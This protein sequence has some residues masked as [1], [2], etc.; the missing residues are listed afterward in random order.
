MKVAINLARVVTEEVSSLTS[1][2][3]FSD[4]THSGKQSS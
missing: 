2:L 3:S 1:I 4:E